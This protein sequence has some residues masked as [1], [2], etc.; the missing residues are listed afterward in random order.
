MNVN[1]VMLLGRL[2][3][4]P[5]LKTLASGSTV[6]EF[7]LAL[8]RRYRSGDELREDVCFVEVT[9][10]NRTAEV[11]AEYFHRGRSIFVEGRLKLDRWES[12]RG[13]RSKLKV[14][15]ERIDFVP[16]GKKS[17]RGLAVAVS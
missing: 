3:R 4:D 7:G 14:I 8:N 1:K 5:E 10:W 13:P 17:E 16:D 11:V 12:E 9:C 6:T 2:T 15:A